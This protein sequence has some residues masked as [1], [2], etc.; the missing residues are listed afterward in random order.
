MAGKPHSVYLP[1]DLSRYKEEY[2]EDEWPDI[3]KETLVDHQLETTGDSKRLRERREAKLAEIEALQKQIAVLEDEVG[4][5]DERLETRKEATENALDDLVDLF[6]LLA[7]R[8]PDTWELNT[9]NHDCAVPVDTV[10][11]L[12]EE[13]DL[14]HYHHQSQSASERLEELLQ[15]GGYEDESMLNLS[16]EAEEYLQGR[17]PMEEEAL[18]EAWAE[19]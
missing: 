3:V 17:T 18:R 4:E 9:R 19:R 6:D 10:L 14:H 16:D 5:I 15:A 1:E 2:L 11:E 13:I 7:Q 8:P 12:A